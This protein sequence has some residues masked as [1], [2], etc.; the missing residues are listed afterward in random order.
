MSLGRFIDLLCQETGCFIYNYCFIVATDGLSATNRIATRQS[1]HRR[2]HHPSAFHS[3]DDLMSIPSHDLTQW[4]PLHTSAPCRHRHHTAPSAARSHLRCCPLT[5]GAMACECRRV[6][7]RG[8]IV[9]TSATSPGAVRCTR[10]AH[11]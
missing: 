3:L 10:R 11:T 2:Y 8:G 5:T 7:Q 1:Y 4:R 9:C 6:R